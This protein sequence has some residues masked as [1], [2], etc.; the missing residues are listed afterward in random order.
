MNHIATSAR[1]K[2]NEKNPPEDLLYE[3]A[4]NQSRTDALANEIEYM[5]IVGK[6]NLFQGKNVSSNQNNHGKRI[7][8]AG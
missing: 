5:N 4:L 2:D 1:N 6:V 8:M 3:S 7:P